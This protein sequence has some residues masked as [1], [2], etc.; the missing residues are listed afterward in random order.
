[1]NNL[2]VIPRFIDNLLKSSCSIGYFKTWTF[3]SIS[4]LMYSQDSKVLTLSDIVKLSS[5]IDSIC[6][7]ICPVYDPS[8]CNCGMT[9]NRFCILRTLFQNKPEE[10]EPSSDEQPVEVEVEVDK[11]EQ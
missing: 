2:L 8:H 3:F 7:G 10:T 6:D 5:V 1:M 4:S 11:D 9:S